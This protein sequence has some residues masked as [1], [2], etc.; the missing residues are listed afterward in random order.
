MYISG[1]IIIM[2]IFESHFQVT[3][4]ERDSTI[5][6]LPP[7]F[8]ISLCQP[9]VRWSFVVHKTFVELHGQ[10]ALQ[11]SAKQLKEMGACMNKSMSHSVALADM[12]L[13]YDELWALW[14]MLKQSCCSSYI[15]KREKKN[16]RMYVSSVNQWPCGLELQTGQGSQKVWRHGLLYIACVLWECSRA[17]TQVS[18]HSV[19]RYS[20]AEK[21]PEKVSVLS[22][23]LSALVTYY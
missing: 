13:H 22:W 9:K 7:D 19:I 1:W 16:A 18:F 5:K 17:S 23:L 14:F 20:A 6:C 15:K 2:M 21:Y 8:L 3:P 4:F 11:H 10:T 12:F